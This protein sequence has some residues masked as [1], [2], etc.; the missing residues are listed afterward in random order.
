[1]WKIHHWARVLISERWKNS[2]SS[3]DAAFRLG[4]DSVFLIKV[5]LGQDQGRARKYWNPQKRSSPNWPWCGDLTDQFQVSSPCLL[6]WKKL[7][8]RERVNWAWQ[9]Q[10]PVAI[11][12]P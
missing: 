10:R 12:Q 7:R 11:L 8:L 1:M 9:A 2:T 5:L 6:F 3:V 4:H